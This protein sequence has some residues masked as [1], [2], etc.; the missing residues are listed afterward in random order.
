MRFPEWRSRLGPACLM[1]GA[2]D[3]L[4]YD[5]DFYSRRPIDFEK[6]FPSAAAWL[7]ANMPP[8]WDGKMS[9]LGFIWLQAY[10][11]TE[12]APTTA[13]DWAA[14]F[15][16]CEEESRTFRTCHAAGISSTVH[17]YAAEGQGTILR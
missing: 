14:F 10:L 2:A 13:A 12:R 7:K 8:A 4:T 3:E 11:R 9:F 6:R 1:A 15:R 16:T 5:L 17:G